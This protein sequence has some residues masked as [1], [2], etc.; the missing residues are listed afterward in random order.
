MNQT[1][2]AQALSCS[3][4]K[5]IAQQTFHSN[6]KIS[7]QVNQWSLYDREIRRNV[8]FLVLIKCLVLSTHK[9]S[10]ALSRP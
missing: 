8:N 2:L 10:F 3:R 1:A 6:S 7:Q 5:V 9:A 4:H